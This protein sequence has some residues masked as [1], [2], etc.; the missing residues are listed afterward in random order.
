MVDKVGEDGATSSGR[1]TPSSSLRDSDLGTPPPSSSSWEPE[2][3]LPRPGLAKASLRLSTWMSGSKPSR[4]P[5]MG[6]LRVEAG[7][8]GADLTP[9]RRAEKTW[10]RRERP[11][12]WTYKNQRNDKTDVISYNLAY[13]SPG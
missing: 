6:L 1:K 13:F 9:V 3:D 8:P 12:S 10:W 4:P 5:L 7:L 2:R 11:S